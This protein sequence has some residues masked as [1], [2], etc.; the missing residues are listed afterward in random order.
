MYNFPF[1]RKVLFYISFADQ[2]DLACVQKA[3]LDKRSGKICLL[4]SSY[5]LAITGIDDRRYWNRIPTE[6]SR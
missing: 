2:G 6:E 5:G 4:I 1:W 3:W